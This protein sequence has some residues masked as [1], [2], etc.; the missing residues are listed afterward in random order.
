MIGRAEELEAIQRFLDAL[1]AGPA[2]LVFEGEPGIGKTTLLRAGADA[3]R[4]R[5]AAVLACGGSGAETR[6]AYAALVDLLR[7]VDDELLERLPAPQREALDV[8]L[9]RA[10]RGDNDVDRRAVAT[11]TLSV[12]EAL[13]RRGPVVVAIDDLQWLDRP[14]AR[15]VE[16]CARRLAG[17]MGLI[18]SRRLDEEGAWG[19][20]LVGAEVRRLAP[21]AALELQ[22]LLRERAH[23]PRRSLVRIAAASG[24]NPFYALALARAVPAGRL[25]SPELRL[26]ASLDEIVA[27]RMAGLGEH[28]E[29]ALLA[30]AALADPTLALL[31]RV[32]GPEA[33]RSLD[34]AEARGLLERHGRR[35]RFTHPI[36]ASGVYARAQPSRRRAMHRRLG[37]AVEDLEER[38]RHLAL[39]GTTPDALVALN[40][41]ARYVRSRGAPDAAAELL[42]LALGLGGGQELCVRAAEHHF[43]AGD[44]Q[45][46]QA[47]LEEA[48]LA[49][50]AGEVRAEALLLLGEVRYK[51][52]SFPAARELLE[53]AQREAGADGPLCVMIDLKLAFILFHLA[54]LS[55]TTPARSALAGAER[56][57]EPGLLAQALAVSAMVDF[58]LGLGLDEPRLARALAL[59]D[60]NLRTG[61]ELVPSLIASFL[62]MW[63]DRLDEARGLVETLVIRHTEHGEEHALAWVQG[64]QRVWIECLAGDLASASGAAGEGVERL[65][66]LETTLGRALAFTSSALLHAYAGRVDM[67]RHGAEEAFALFERSGWQGSVGWPLTILGFVEL[68]VGDFRAAAARLGPPAAM[69]IAAGLRE[70]AAG[71]AL[72]AGDAAEALIAVGRIDE[73]ERLVAQLEARGSALAR[74]WAIAVGARCRGLLSAAHGDVAAAEQALERALIAHER[75]PMPIERARSLLALGRIRRRRRRRLAAKAALEE[76]L[77]IF[78]A[79]GSP[80]WAEQAAAEIAC[81]GLHRRTPDAL[82]PSEERVATLAASGLTNRQVA[83]ALHVSPKTV[84]AQLAVTYRKLGI[85]SRAELG[86][87]MTRRRPVE[88]APLQP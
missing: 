7:D 51:D 1:T 11:A 25:W 65:M 42:E 19:A 79:V 75:L 40:A 55:A 12:L 63:T 34:V 70:P 26:P 39:A 59:E 32:L 44:P 16:F 68:S 84:E 53:Q 37:H 47:L 58:N 13:A 52:D 20:G 56:L 6:L 50:P 77:A 38:A 24:G 48:I 46:A 49:L 4:R 29:E 57:G 86:A 87:H 85:H 30:V 80:R 35:L 3:A 60:P 54:P 17:N 83:A 27:T 73:A 67:A 82:T 64:F 81:L 21:F 14:S 15:V 41:A 36:L 2:V 45:R 76:A 69:A 66:A 18:A 61:T 88:R 31:E 22:R 8:A 71:G 43:D 62:F 10:G 9:L 78:E 23:A 74:T 5:G 28:V 72:F 33:A